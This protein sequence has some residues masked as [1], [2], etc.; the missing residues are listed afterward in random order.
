MF[1]REGATVGGREITI[2]TGKMAKQASGAVVI[3]MGDTMVL[4]TANGSKGPREG[5][6]FMPLTC[7]YQEKFYAAGKVPGSY[8]RRE[9]RP[10]EA[11]VLV[12]RLIDRPCRP[13]FPKSWRIDTQIIANVISY[14]DAAPPDV[15]AMTG[16]VGGDHRFR[17]GLGRSDCRHPRRLRRR[18]VRRLPHDGTAG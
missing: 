9:G 4:V 6:D 3:R 13:L 11:E 16:G 15:L 18:R 2:E 8:F 1:V 5:M 17:P 12:C 10:S 7:E 14:D